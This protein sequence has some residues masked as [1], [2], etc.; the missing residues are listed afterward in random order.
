MLKF[1]WKKFQLLVGPVITEKQAN[2]YK[3]SFIEYHGYYYYGSKYLR[4]VMYI[5][6]FDYFR[7]ISIT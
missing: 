2:S 1:E 4:D 7:F 6:H 5:W 3:Y